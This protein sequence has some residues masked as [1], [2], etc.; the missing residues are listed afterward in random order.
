VSKAKAD[1]KIV[2]IQDPRSGRTVEAYRTEE[3][4]A[5]GIKVKQAKARS[6]A[7]GRDTQ[8]HERMERERERRRQEAEHEN[9]ARRAIL[10]AVRER[11]AAQPRSEFDLRMVA[12]AMVGRLPY[13]DRDTLLALYGA[14]TSEALLATVQQMGPDEL[15]RLLL[16]CALVDGIACDQ[17]SL[18]RPPESLMRAAGHYGIDTAA[19]RAGLAKPVQTPA[20]EVPPPAQPKARRKAQAEL[21]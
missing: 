17:W 21:I 15:G 13:D 14:E 2:I 4:A 6:A 19:V 3:V 8:A 1:L 11:A 7:G 5:A 16:D 20:T 12:V 9:A 10:A 18:E